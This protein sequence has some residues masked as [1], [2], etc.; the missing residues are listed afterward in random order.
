MFGRLVCWLSVGVVFTG[1]TAFAESRRPQTIEGKFVHVQT[2]L[3]LSSAKVLCGQLDAVA[4]QLAAEY[5]KP[6]REPI[7]VLV[8]EN[9]TN[10]PA[11][12][13]PDD[14]RKQI[15][16]KAGTTI[17]ERLT[18]DE[19]VVSV[20]STVY[21]CADGRTPQHELVH[22]YCW[23]TFGRVGPDW[24]AEGLAELFAN[25]RPDKTGVQA[26]G[27]VIEY[28]KNDKAPPSPA[29][30]VADQLGDRELWQKYAH[31]WALCYLL[32]QHPDYAATFRQFSRELLGGKQPDFTRA[33]ADDHALQVREYLQFLRDMAPGYEFPSD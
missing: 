7:S 14:A 10:W 4:E 15:A 32:S 16:A 20:R 27:Y 30:I 13:I 8:V 21:S 25:R 9:L 11:G 3:E 26:P 12:S 6:L 18:D 29:A 19:K 33:F 17:T 1:G 22:A 23:Q 31:R 28:L 5:E 2:D 24:F